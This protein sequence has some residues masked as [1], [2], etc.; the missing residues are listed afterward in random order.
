MPTY[1]VE[2]IRR[3]YK[4]VEVK[5]VSAAAAA[6]I[7]EGDHPG[8]RANAVGDRGIVGKCESCRGIIFDDDEYQTDIEGEV[9]ICAE[10]CK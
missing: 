4:T 7:A 10:C 9:R 6:T 3:D 1:E 2:L 5:A 8:F